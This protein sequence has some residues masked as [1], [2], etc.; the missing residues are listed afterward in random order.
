MNDR[1]SEYV[2]AIEDLGWT[3]VE[4]IVVRSHFDESTQIRS[5]TVTEAPPRT[6]FLASLLDGLAGIAVEADAASPRQFLTVDGDR[7]TITASNGEFIY[8]RLDHD[9]A[10]GLILAERI[11]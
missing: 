7:I 11:D 5:I 3:D 2:D 1:A 6:V 8:R 10:R 4:S 9:E